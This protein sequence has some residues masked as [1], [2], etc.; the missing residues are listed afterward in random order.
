MRKKRPIK[1]LNC[2]TWEITKYPNVTAAA[3]DGF[4]TDCINECL[5]GYRQ[6]HRNH[7]WSYDTDPLSDRELDLTLTPTEAAEILNISHDIAKNLMK[8]ERAAQEVTKR[9]LLR[10][11]I[12]PLVLVHGVSIDECARKFCVSSSTICKILGWDDD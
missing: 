11:T 6:V 4:R 7:L 9:E 10:Q 1:A 12:E 2:K 8:N 3:K 5:D